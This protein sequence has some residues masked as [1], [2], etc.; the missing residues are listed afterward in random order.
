[1]IL[2]YS[3]LLRIDNTILS[4]TAIQTIIIT[5]LKKDP[6]NDPWNFCMF[7][8]IQRFTF[9]S[10]GGVYLLRHLLQLLVKVISFGFHFSGGSPDLFKFILLSVSHLLF[11]ILKNFH[12]WLV[13]PFARFLHVN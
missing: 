13:A 4:S 6:R 1:M 9:Y 12:F 10:L 7:L 8:F 3:F 2:S 5:L 11:L